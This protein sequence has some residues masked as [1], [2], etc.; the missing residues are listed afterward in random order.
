MKLAIASDHAGVELKRLI[1]TELDGEG[2][3]WQDLGTWDSTPVD[4]PD[5]ALAV[6]EKVIS[7]ECDLGVLICGTGAGMAI[8]ANKV[9]GVRAAVCHD[10]FT[11]RAAREHNAVNVLALGARV[12]GPG[13][14][15]EV[16]RAWLAAAPAEGRHRR[17]VDKITAIER[18]YGGER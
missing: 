17:R 12:V 1:L 6:A 18:R 14:A 13:L 7:G 11:A 3:R 2:H 4:Y 15:M 10:T 5:L 16:L 8:A 9:P